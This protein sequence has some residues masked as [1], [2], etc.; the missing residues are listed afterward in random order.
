[1]IDDTTLFSSLVFTN[2]V[3]DLATWSNLVCNLTNPSLD[4]KPGVSFDLVLKIHHICYS[5]CTLLSSS[6]PSPSRCLVV[7]RRRTTW[8]EGEGIGGPKV[9]YGDMEEVGGRRRI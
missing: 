8:K 2:L 7:G 9:G 4:L 3:L 1:M 6:G 5:G